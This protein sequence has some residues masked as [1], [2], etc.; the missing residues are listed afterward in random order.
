MSARAPAAVCGYVYELFN[1]RFRWSMRSNPHDGVGVCLANWLT[2]WFC[3]T[4]ATDG[5]AA[6]RAAARAE[7]RSSN[8][9]TA[10]DHTAPTE[11][12]CR[13]ATPRAAAATPEAVT[14]ESLNTTR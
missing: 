8:P 7:P 9:R 3:S 4:D 13:A 14:A 1:G 11:P 12:A 5:N 10:C 6:T 2:V